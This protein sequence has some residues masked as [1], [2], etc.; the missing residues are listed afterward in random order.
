[1]IARDRDE[2][3]PT[4]RRLLLARALRSVGQGMLAVDFALYLHA[5]GWRGSTI[6]LVLTGAGLFGAG[7]STVIGFASDRLR[8]K[9]FLLIYE[10]LALLCSVAVLLSVRSWVI[11][12]AA[13]AGGFGRGANGAAGPF[14]P[15]EQA[16]LAQ[17]VAPPR[18]ARIYSLNSG[19]GFFG[20]AAGALV[21]ALPAIWQRW[22]E[23]AASFRPL[24]LLVAIGSTANLYLLSRAQ[25]ELRRSEHD[26]DPG[27]RQQ[28]TTV[29][30]AENRLLG[31]LV[32]INA[33]NGLAIGLIGPL[34]SYWFALRFHVGPKEIGPVL[35]LTFALTG[36]ASL[37]TGRL[38]EQIGIV[39]SVVWGRLIGLVFLGLMPAMPTYWLA[40]LLYVLRSV[41]SRG[42]AGARQA[43]AVSL[44]RDERRG[45]AASLN[46][47]SFQ[48]PQ[49]AGP[50]IAGHL[51]EAGRFALPLYISTLFQGIYLVAYRRAFRAHE[52]P[53][54]PILD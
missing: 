9:P 46:S 7:L 41:F 3:H 18:R 19:L 13:V 21:A 45:L 6:G 43:L 35:A 53:L 16:W 26:R 30:R 5:L 12:A 1:M 40:S 33:F 15:A 36:V 42:S 27:A 25:E 8:R 31:Q 44:V 34:I 2:L 20:M 22:M 48:L 11:V 52:P 32:L 29:R 28:D 14:S 4:T 39:Q 38:S 24:F 54:E 47:V 49:S 23:G 37:A 10:S 17:N 51:L 50:S